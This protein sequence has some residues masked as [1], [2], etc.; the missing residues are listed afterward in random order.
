MLRPTD[1]IA[2]DGFRLLI[3]KKDNDPMQLMADEK[4]VFKHISKLMGHEIK[5]RKVVT[6][7]GF[8]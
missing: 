2:P 8:R 3:F 7:S 5:V 1:E 4:L 6:L